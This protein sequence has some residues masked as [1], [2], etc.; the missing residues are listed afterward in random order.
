MSYGVYWVK[1]VQKKNEDFE[2]PTLQG[3]N[4]MAIRNPGCRFACPGLGAFGLSAR[5]HYRLHLNKSSKLDCI[6]FAR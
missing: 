6:W 5:V 2:H 4:S 1:N 3:V